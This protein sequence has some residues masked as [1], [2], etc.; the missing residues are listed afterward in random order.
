MTVFL[1]YARLDDVVVDPVVAALDQHN[2]RY[3]FDRRD[4][5]VSFPWKTEIGHAIRSSVLVVVLESDAWHASKPCRSELAVAVALEKPVIHIGVRDT[6]PDDVVEIIERTLSALTP[7]QRSRTD[8]LARSGSWHRNGRAAVGL[9]GGR[10]LEQ[11][12]RVVADDRPLPAE[13]LDFVALSEVR[14]ARRRRRRRVGA[15]MTLAAFGVGWLAQEVDRRGEEELRGKATILAAAAHAH[16][17][18]QGSPYAGLRDAVDEIRGGDDDYLIRS[19]LV[20]T[21]D[22]PVPEESTIVPGNPLTGFAGRTSAVL[23]VRDTTEA[24]LDLSG[25]PMPD[26]QGMASARAVGVGPITARAV[27]G[28]VSAVGTADGKVVVDDGSRPPVSIGPDVDHGPVTALD[29]STRAPAVAVV[30]RGSGSVS[31]YDPATGGLTRRIPVGAPL[32]AVAISPDGRTIAVGVGENVVLADVASGR[33]RVDLRG[34]TGQVGDV[35]WSDDGTSVWAINGEHRVSRWRWRDGPRLADDR[36]AWFV[37]LSAPGPDGSLIAVTRSGDVHRIG[38]GGDE[39]LVRTG[40]TVLSFSVDG[41]NHRVLLGTSDR[42]LHVL[43]VRNGIQ[44]VVD[45]RPECIPLSTTWVP[46]TD[47]AMVACLAGPLRRVDT[48]AASPSHD[49]AVP[50]GG[51]SAVTAGADGTVYLGT[52]NG[53]VYRTTADATELQV[54]EQPPDPTEWRTITLSADGGTL[55]LTGS[56]TGNLGHLLVGRMANGEWT[57]YTVPLL[58][59]DAEQSSAAAL[60]PDGAIAAIGVASGTVHFLATEAGNLGLT[61]T[62]VSGAVTGLQFTNGGLVASSRDGV[63]ERMDP[64]AGCESAATL[65]E[66]ADHRLAEGRRLGLVE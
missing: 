28:D 8:L 12:Q 5:P 57:W 51:A 26:P 11:L 46:N 62:A 16:F 31:V 55:L 30:H 7:V 39:I 59:D 47:L 4:I 49:L 52:A 33:H 35:R 50:A 1:S 13:S 44:R 19:A 27:D 64:C 14:D 9:V 15:V 10:L 22:T 18:A 40:L 23:T 56:G 36:G 2:I 24:V 29:V 37:G 54:I 25:A 3:W 42:G 38:D 60:S 58:K 48:S 32:H 65:A 20:E 34:P 63:V 45:D 43:D 6:G 61:R 66:L 17:R 41:S 21:L 53:R